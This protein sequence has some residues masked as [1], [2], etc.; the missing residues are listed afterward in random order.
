M[1]TDHHV[2]LSDLSR[3]Q[4]KQ[5]ADDITEELARREHEDRDALEQRLRDLAEEEGFDPD[6]VRFKKPRGRKPRK[7][8][9]NGAID[10]A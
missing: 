2:P 10:H 8:K 3:A 5:L 6:Q 4:L 1:T 7:A 9:S